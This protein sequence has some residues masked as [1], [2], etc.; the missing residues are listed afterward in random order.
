MFEKGGTICLDVETKISPVHIDYLDIATIYKRGINNENKKYKFTGKTIEYKGTTLNQIVALKSFGNI[1]EGDIGGWIEKENN[2]YTHG[3][4]WVYPKSMVMGD[5]RVGGDSIV[6]GLSV[7]SENALVLNESL[8]DDSIVRG[9]MRI[10]NAKVYACHLTGASCIDGECLLTRCSI[11]S[12][13]VH[14]TGNEWSNV[15]FNGKCHYKDFNGDINFGYDER[16]SPAVINNSNDLVVMHNLGYSNRTIYY[17]VSS[18]IVVA[19]CFYGKLK[20]FRKEV[21]EKYEG[22]GSYYPAIEYLRSLRKAYKK[23]LKEKQDD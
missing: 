14:L 19:G 23:S 18:N 17:A 7:V 20:D 13:N 15:I 8:V 1:E 6:K 5:A 11:L 12:D 2:L 10:R 21:D 16:S 4:C 3:N 9:V 22:K